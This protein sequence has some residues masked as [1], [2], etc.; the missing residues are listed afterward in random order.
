MWV[1]VCSLFLSPCHHYAFD[2]D[3]FFS[4]SVCFSVVSTT[5]CHVTSCTQFVVCFC[6]IGWFLSAAAAADVFS[7]IQSFIRMHVC[8]CVLIMY[9]FPQSSFCLIFSPPSSSSFWLWIGCCSG[10]LTGSLLSCFTWGLALWVVHV[11]VYLGVCACVC[12]RVCMC[13]SDDIT[14]Y[15]SFVCVRIRK[16]IRLDT[17]ILCSSRCIA[18]VL[19]CHFSWLLLLFSL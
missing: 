17:G 1:S 14:C 4:S 10:L 18:K 2:I 9:L 5:S 7:Y 12:V 6:C 16:C 3:L 8:V 13:R 15:F 11:Y 19:S